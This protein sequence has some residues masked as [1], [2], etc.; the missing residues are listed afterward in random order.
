MPRPF[1]VRTSGG[2]FFF[3]VAWIAMFL[4]AYNSLFYPMAGTAAAIIGPICFLVGYRKW[5]P[6]AA[7]KPL[8]VVAII[9][10]SKVAPYAF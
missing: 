3:S 1:F 7:I 8:I 9:V 2:I 10:L 5:R 4:F 6:Q